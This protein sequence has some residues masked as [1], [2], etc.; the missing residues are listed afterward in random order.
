M[1]NILESLKDL[2]NPE[3]L[4]EL[5][6]TGKK[7]IQEFP[8]LSVGIAAGIGFFVGYTGIQKTARSFQKAAS[9]RLSNSFDPLGIF[10][11]ALNISLS[12]AGKSMNMPREKPQA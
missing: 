12:Q 9:E 4:S 11:N 8:L 5:L 6:E 10:M 2:E 1:N 3:V 7:K